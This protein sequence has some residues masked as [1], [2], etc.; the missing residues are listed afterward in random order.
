MIT[1]HRTKVS[2]WVF[3]VTL[4]LYVLATLRFGKLQWDI[5]QQTTARMP[6][7]FQS[8]LLNLGSMSATVAMLLAT[9][10]LG[11]RSSAALWLTGLVLYEQLASIA[12]ILVSI[13]LRSSPASYFAT[14][15]LVLLVLLIA[16][17]LVFLVKRDEVRRL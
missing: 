17:V 1:E 13:Q 14:I 12:P 16:A 4:A 5:L 8:P 15:A 7:G 3:R 9:V 2:N 10:A 11:L 6:E